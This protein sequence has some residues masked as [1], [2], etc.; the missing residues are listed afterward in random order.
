MGT[1]MDI[2]GWLYYDK[3]VNYKDFFYGAHLFINWRTSADEEWQIEVFNYTNIKMVNRTF[4]LI[5][6]DLIAEAKINFTA[7]E[8]I[9]R[10]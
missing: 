3:V 6:R 9:E 7:L 4:G 1:Y 2:M 8:E 5:A 10:S